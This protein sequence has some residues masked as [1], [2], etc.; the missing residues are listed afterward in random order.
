MQEKALFFI[1]G[2]QE[3]FKNFRIHLIKF[4]LKEDPHVKVTCIHFDNPGNTSLPAIFQS[5]VNWISLKGYHDGPMFFDF[6]PLLRLLG[7][8]IYHRPKNIIAFNAKPIFYIG[9]LKFF[10]IAPKNTVALL[11]G[12]GLGFLPLV[13]KG[14]ANTLKRKIITFSIWNFKKWIFLNKG[15]PKTLSKLG[16]LNRCAKQ[17]NI[18]G[19]GIDFSFFQSSLNAEERW[20][21]QSVGFC[22]RFIEEKGIHVV[23]KIAKIVKSKKKDVGFHL[24][25][26]ATN[27]YDAL[28]EKLL[29]DWKKQGIIESAE[30]FDD[31]REFYKKQTII[32]LPTTYNEGLPAVAMESQYMGMPILLNKLPQ[33]SE[34]L[35]KELH[36][37]LIDNN[38]PQDFADVIIRYLS[39]LEDYK[40][41]SKQG[42]KFARSQ[43]DSEQKNKEI[44]NFLFEM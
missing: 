1:G 28:S 20:N 29:S 6:L 9:I 39:S 12:L 7:I 22:G 13:E 38:I 43:F 10:R 34:A 23:A 40:Y 16:A 30:H 26:R 24:A 2:T 36:N 17:L 41:A 15:D 31:I 4:I 42:C 25:G 3:A 14:I 32:I 21:L 33:V 18:N 8:L 44:F 27:F 19:I 37:Q 35:P 5:R 11:E